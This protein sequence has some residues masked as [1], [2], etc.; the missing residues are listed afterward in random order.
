M[1][2]TEANIRSD[3][4][5]IF[6]DMSASGV[7][8]TVKRFPAGKEQQDGSFSVF[9]A[10]QLTDEELQFSGFRKR[11]QFSVYADRANIGATDE[12]DVLE[13]A[14]G[15]RLRIYKIGPGPANILIR[16]ELGDEFGDE[17]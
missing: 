3:I 11:Y 6:A 1:G 10:K 4:A 2:L 13:M 15:T 5:G 16:L 8:E 7:V 9:R 17:D 12:G 14:D